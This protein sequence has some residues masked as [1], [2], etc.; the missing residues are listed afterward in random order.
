[1][2]FNGAIISDS[3]GFQVGSLIKRNPKLGHIDDE[4][5]HFRQEGGRHVLLTPEKS[6]EFQMSLGV[7][8]VIVLDDFTDPDGDK[9]EAEDSVLRTLSWAERSKREFE[10]IC[11]EKGLS[12]SSRPYLLGVAQGGEFM[13]LREKCTRELVKIGFDGIG[14][15]GWPFADGKL[16][17][18]SAEVIAQ[19]VP[20][21]YLLYGLGIG[22]PGDIVRLSDLGYDIFDCVLPTRDARHGRLYV[23]NSDSIEKI[24]V[25][26]KNFYSYLTPGRQKYSDDFSPIS[27]ACDCL[28]C[29][30]YSKAYLSHLFRIKDFTAGRLATIHNLRF[31][32]IL[33]EKLRDS[34]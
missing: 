3:G 9:K 30:R 21:D 32:S 4:G 27:T 17:F 13:D 31:F 8:M 28:A 5:A 11:K 2:D 25:H 14:W 15:G 20:S 18:R 16:N 10:K 24:D 23:Y 1:M 6:V 22:K 26:A 7:D 33:L 29:R 34:A 12:K 19:N